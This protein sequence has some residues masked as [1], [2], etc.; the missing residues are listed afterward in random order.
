MGKKGAIKQERAEAELDKFSKEGPF[1][2]AE[3][4]RIATICNG[5]DDLQA[6]DDLDNIAGKF[7]PEEFAKL[8]NPEAQFP[9]SDTK[10]LEIWGNGTG[11]WKLSYLDP[12]FT[13]AHLIEIAKRP[14]VFGSV[15]EHFNWELL[16]V[17]KR[18][19]VLVQLRLELRYREEIARVKQMEK[20]AKKA[21]THRDHSPKH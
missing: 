18:V 9:N 4:F 20:K 14:D 21:K 5:V 2:F 1:T 16:D 6:G 19:G 13:D 10:S 15:I 17:D 8:L 7:E 11:D 3:T 12:G